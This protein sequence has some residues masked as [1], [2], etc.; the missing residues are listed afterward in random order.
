MLKKTSFQCFQWTYDSALLQPRPQ[1]K[2][3]P[4][5]Y[6]ESM[7]ECAYL[8]HIYMQKSNALSIME[9]SWQKI[10][11]TSENW[12]FWRIF[13]DWIGIQPSTSSPGPLRAWNKWPQPVLNGTRQDLSNDIWFNLFA[14]W[15]KLDHQNRTLAPLRDRLLSGKKVPVNSVCWQ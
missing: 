5:K 11:N 6:S 12:G 2:L 4:T 7:T 15:V 1:R 3:S 10:E 14:F 13:V 9:A 8:K